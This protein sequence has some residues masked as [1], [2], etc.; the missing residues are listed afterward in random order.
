MP[1]VLTVIRWRDIPAQVVAKDGRAAARRVLPDRFHAAIDRAAMR[2]G[3]VSESDYV[4]EWLSDREPCG[5]DLEAAVAAL[6]EAVERAHP[7]A[8]LDELVENGGWRHPAGGAA[9]DAAPGGSA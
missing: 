2:A 9:P 4:G 8:A 5:E 7:Q 1:P 3:L 6:A